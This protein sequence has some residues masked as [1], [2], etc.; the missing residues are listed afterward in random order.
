MEATG[1]GSVHRNILCERSVWK[2]LQA[3]HCLSQNKENLYPFVTIQIFR[4]WKILKE[5]H[6]KTQAYAAWTRNIPKIRFVLVDRET[7]RPWFELVYQIQIQIRF[8]ANRPWRIKI[9]C[10]S[11]AIFCM[12]RNKQVICV[13][14]VVSLTILQYETLANFSCFV[15]VFP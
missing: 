8:L 12:W 5:S 1:S 11:G 7:I 2:C 14:C 13:M 9:S 10:M 3:L 4:T 6:S 15:V